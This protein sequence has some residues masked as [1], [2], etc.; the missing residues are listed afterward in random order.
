VGGVEEHPWASSDVGGSDHDSHGGCRSIGT[1]GGERRRRRW[2]QLAS[3]RRW[4][5]TVRKVFSVVLVE[6][7]L[8]V[9]CW[10]IE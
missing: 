1:G 7:C 10:A 9:L 5:G 3:K 8:C 4:L 6:E 2:R